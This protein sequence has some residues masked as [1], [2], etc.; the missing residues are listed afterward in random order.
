MVSIV[1]HYPECTPPGGQP[2]GPNNVEEDSQMR[3]VQE[4]IDDLINPDYQRA[5][6]AKDALVS[7]KKKAVRPLLQAMSTPSNKQLWQIITVL[8]RIGDPSVVPAIITC[9][10]SENAAIQASAA[11]CLGTL[12]DQRAIAPLLDFIDTHGESSAVIWVL[13]ALGR[14]QAHAAVE[15]LMRLV[16][17]TDS[18][19]I[20]YTAIEA[21]GY[22]GDRKA[23]DVILACTRDEDH[24]VRA[25][26][27]MALRLLEAH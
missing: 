1:S 3:P 25:R 26:V 23:V 4:L 17:Q 16:D 14:L 2:K 8:E 9:L 20:R 13:E 18:S 10:Y 24:H 12:N 15:R 5:Q 27:E 21:L 22:I 11:H 6:E 7:L 19:V